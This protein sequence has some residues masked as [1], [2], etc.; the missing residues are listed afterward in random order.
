MIL[1]GQQLILQTP[2]SSRHVFKLI[3]LGYAKEID[4]LSLC[5]SLLGSFHYVAP[6]LFTSREYSCTVD[7]W[8]L[9]NVAHECLTGSRPFL[10]NSSWGDDVSS[11]LRVPEDKPRDV[12]SVH[13]DLDGHVQR[14]CSVAPEVLVPKCVSYFFFC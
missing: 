1:V 3:D 11:R 8:S 5:S 4:P 12:V 9:G 7:Y 2:G 13:V 10:L 6:E 14:S